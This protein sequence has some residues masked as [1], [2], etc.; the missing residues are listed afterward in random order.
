VWHT[1]CF[2]GII[3]EHLWTF[4]KVRSYQKEFSIFLFSFC[5]KFCPKNQNIK[6][7]LIFFSQRA[8]LRLPPHLGNVVQSLQICYL[9]FNL[10]NMKT[11][12]N[13]KKRV[14]IEV[15]L[16]WIVNAMTIVI[17]YVIL[18]QK[19]IIFIFDFEG[20]CVLNLQIVTTCKMRG[21]FQVSIQ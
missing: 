15:V 17:I 21:V 14:I 8:A 1:L 9:S 7:H 10:Y 18:A 16:G 12:Y 19:F 4:L 20:K 3:I 5:P 6:L 11:L 2:D 13:F